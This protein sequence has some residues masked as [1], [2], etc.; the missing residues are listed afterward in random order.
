MIPKSAAMSSNGTLNSVC[1]ANETRASTACLLV[2]SEVHKSDTESI[3]S[4]SKELEVE[5]EV[6]EQD[7]EAESE[8]K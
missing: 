4:E 2:K 1:R 3:K 6:G 7:S 8:D 5:S